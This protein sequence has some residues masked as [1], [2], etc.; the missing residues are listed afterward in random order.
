MLSQVIPP[1]GPLLAQ[2]PSGREIH[3]IKPYQPPLLSPDLLEAM[4]APPERADDYGGYSS[5]DEETAVGP[6]PIGAFPGK[7]GDYRTGTPN[8]F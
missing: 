3:S 6:S 7:A 8:Y 2:M 1:T 4:R 5:S